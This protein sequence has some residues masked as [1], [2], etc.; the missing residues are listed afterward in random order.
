[1][2]NYVNPIDLQDPFEKL[3]NRVK[4]ANTGKRRG[5]VTAALTE[6]IDQI[7]KAN[8][9]VELAE[10]QHNID[11]AEEQKRRAEARIEQLKS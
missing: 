3:V 11:Q 7:V 5:D 9:A 8:R 6:L 2:S 1:M 4:N 10:E